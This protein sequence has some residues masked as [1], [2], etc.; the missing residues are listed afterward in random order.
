M[1]N[2]I[3]TTETTETTVNGQSIPSAITGQHGI[4]LTDS[5]KPLI[6]ANTTIK[7]SISVTQTF[8]TFFKGSPE[9]AL[10]QL[11]ELQNLKPETNTV[12]PNEMG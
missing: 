11:R 1:N 5:K 8:G 2:Q 7:G 9:D 4:N 12:K 6:S 10:K 3:E